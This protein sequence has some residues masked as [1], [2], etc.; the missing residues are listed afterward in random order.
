MVSWRDVL[1]RL[2][3]EVDELSVRCG[4]MDEADQVIARLE[5]SDLSAPVELDRCSVCML[6]EL[7]NEFSEVMFIPI[8]GS[9]VSTELY[10][11]D[12]V[13]IEIGDDVG[14]VVARSEARKLVEKLREL[15]FEIDDS[16]LGIIERTP[17][18]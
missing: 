4:C 1:R 11:L 14:H 18:E 6:T 8:A 13:V 5:Y 2:K 12:D 7:L 16:I 3:E 9:L 17:R 15:G 10:V